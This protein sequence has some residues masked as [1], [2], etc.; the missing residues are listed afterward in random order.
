MSAMPRSLSARSVHS[1]GR[2]RPLTVDLR[3]VHAEARGDPEVS[4][5]AAGGDQKAPGTDGGSYAD[6]SRKRTVRTGSRRDRMC[7]ERM[8]DERRRDQIDEVT[9]PAARPTDRHRAAARNACWLDFEPRCRC[10]KSPCEHECNDGYCNRDDAKSPEA[11][12]HR[13]HIT[14]LAREHG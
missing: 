6:A 14:P 13:R 7:D 1:L 8:P 2:C 11:P 4:A 5:A 10:G 3:S 12:R 9:G